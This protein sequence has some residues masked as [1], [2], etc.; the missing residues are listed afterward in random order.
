M[1][2]TYVSEPFITTKLGRCQYPSRSVPTNQDEID[3]GPAINKSRHCRHAPIGADSGGGGGK[4]GQF[5]LQAE[6]GRRIQ[7][8]ITKAV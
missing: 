1:P 8:G 3:M 5:S 4:R 2:G 6:K 7:G